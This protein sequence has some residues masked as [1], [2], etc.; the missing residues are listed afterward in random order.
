MAGP[1]FGYARNS[2]GALEHA[3][4][5]Q[6]TEPINLFL[7]NV[8]D[9]LTILSDTT[10]PTKTIDIETT[11]TVPVDGNM[12]CLKE[13]LNFYQGTILSVAAIAGNQYTLTLDDPLDFAFTTAGGCS[14]TSR[15]MS[16]DGSVTP[17]VFSVTPGGLHESV[18]WDI[19]TATFYIQGTLAMDDGDFG[20]Q[21]ALTNGC[22]LRFKSGSFYK[23]VLNFKNNG[24]L[25]QEC[26]NREYAIAPPAAK[27]SVSAL[28]EGRDYTQHGV[29][30]RMAAATAQEFQ[31]VVQDDLTAVDFMSVKIFGHVVE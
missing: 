19:Y 29:S 25:R 23:N 20:D 15:D 22:V 11:G 4:Q 12:V 1:S 5:D 10:I 27:T 21:A 3:E 28:K 14:L 24:D 8:L 26:G 9:T 16:V 17:V 13:F 30:A 2:R 7:V 31:L 18:Q 6:F